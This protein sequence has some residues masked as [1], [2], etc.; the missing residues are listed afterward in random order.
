MPTTG[1]SPFTNE[2]GEIISDAC[3]YDDHS[4]CNGRGCN[5]ECHAI[6]NDDN[7]TMDDTG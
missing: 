1:P 7:S 3:G 5:C 6:I 2:Y 4:Q